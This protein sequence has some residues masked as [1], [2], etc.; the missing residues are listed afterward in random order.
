MAESGRSFQVNKQIFKLVHPTARQRAL[1][2]VQHAAEGK[3][4][5][6]KDATRSLDQNARYWSKGVLYQISQQAKIHGRRFDSEVWHEYFKKMFL[7]VVELPDGS[8]VGKSSTKLTVKE[9][10]DFCTQVEAFAVQEL[11]VRFFD[12]RV[13]EYA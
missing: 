8:V 2:A 5:E 10:S 7:G 11:G 9:F 6:I 3:V 4:V 13:Q 12:E 1:M